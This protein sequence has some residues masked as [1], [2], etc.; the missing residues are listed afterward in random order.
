[1]DEE[2]RF[3]V[4]DVTMREG[5]PPPAGRVAEKIGKP[6]GEVLE[7]FRRLAEN[8]MLVLQPG[9]EIL[10]AGPFSAVPTPFA[11]AT[12]AFSTFANCIWDA[13]GIPAMVKADAVI[14]TNCADCGEEAHI[15][16][17]NGEVS[18][19]GFMHFV[20]PVRLWWMHIVYT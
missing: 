19:E 4:Y 1:M 11:V 15:A 5:V 10:M 13:L 14:H 3:A 7:S 20:V 6:T 2:V 9:G 12:D 18:G 8:K 17:R 16:V